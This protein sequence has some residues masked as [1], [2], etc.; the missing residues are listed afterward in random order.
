MSIDAYGP[1]PGDKRLLTRFGAEPSV[2]TALP[3]DP[4][5]LARLESK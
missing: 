3:D 1:S 4:R 2:R 5:P